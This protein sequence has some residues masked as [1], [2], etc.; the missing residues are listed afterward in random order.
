MAEGDAFED[1]P[2]VEIHAVDDADLVAVL[3][4]LADPGQLHLHWN[5]ER[6]QYVAAPNPRQHEELRRIERAAAEH[7]LARSLHLAEFTLCSRGLAMSAVEPLAF[8]VFDA[9]GAVVF[10]EQN[11]GDELVELDPEAVRVFLRGLQHTLARP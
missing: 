4:I 9:G 10:I 8:Q 1:V 2:A 5:A 3:Q 11:P 6:L 7:D